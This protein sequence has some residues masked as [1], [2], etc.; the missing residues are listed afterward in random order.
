MHG[1]GQ[2][3]FDVFLPIS[4][5][6]KKERSTYRRIR[7]L[8]DGIREDDERRRKEAIQPT[9]FAGAE[10]VLEV[11]QCFRSSAW[12]VQSCCASEPRAVL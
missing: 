5:L 2:S 6:R 11:G 8:D 1:T 12:F 7:R 3:T 9:E 4:E 10:R